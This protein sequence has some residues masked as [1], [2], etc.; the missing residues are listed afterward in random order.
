MKTHAIKYGPDYRDRG[1]TQKEYTHSTWCGYVRDKVS[2]HNGDIT[3]K[4]C[5]R[6]LTLK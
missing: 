4:L 1:Q 3:C 6:A 5:L 2:H